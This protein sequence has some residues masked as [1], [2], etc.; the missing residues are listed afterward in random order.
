M[1]ARHA[2]LRIQLMLNGLISSMLNFR[3]DEMQGSHLAAP[4]MGLAACE[5]MQIPMNQGLRWHPWASAILS[6]ILRCHNARPGFVMTRM[7]L[8]Y[9][10]TAISREELA[11]RFMVHDM[12]N[13]M[14]TVTKNSV[15]ASCPIRAV[16]KS[17]IT[18]YSMDKVLTMFSLWA[19]IRMALEISF[20]CQNPTLDREGVLEKIRIAPECHSAAHLL[21][22]WFHG[23]KMEMMHE[24]AWWGELLRQTAMIAAMD[25]AISDP[26]GLGV[27]S[28]E[29]YLRE[30]ALIRYA[31]LMEDVTA[32]LDGTGVLWM[33]SMVGGVHMDKAL[34]MS[35]QIFGQKWHTSEPHMLMPHKN[36]AV[37][38]HHLKRGN[39]DVLGLE[40]HLAHQLLTQLLSLA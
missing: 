12:L 28:A 3:T 23:N 17:K 39:N 31:S 34:E 40:L 13:N 37:T 21:I 4:K 22:K 16:F 15:W 24:V 18:D 10:T 33:K 27:G 14:P 7:P 35:P 36:H 32:S 29:Q 5:A 25:V 1:R 2:L 6:G 8:F 19:L 26:Q 30:M 11:V 38:L 9:G 20:T